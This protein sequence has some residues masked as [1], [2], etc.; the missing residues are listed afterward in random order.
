MDEILSTEDHQSL[1]QVVR[2]IISHLNQRLLHAA[3]C[4]TPSAVYL[5]IVGDKVWEFQ[6][7]LLFPNA[8][9]MEENTSVLV[10][11]GSRGVTEMLRD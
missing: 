4:V 6:G 10:L 1:N 8:T 2:K 3:R 9:L 7:Y 5:L 11:F